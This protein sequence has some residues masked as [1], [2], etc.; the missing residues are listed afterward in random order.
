MDERIF[1]RLDA[2][3][4]T[5]PVVLASVLVTRGAV[6]RK[7]GSRMLVWEDGSEFSV[8]GGLAEARVIDAARSLLHDVRG[9]THATL[10]IDL[11]GR[12][13]SAGICGGRMR[14]ALRRWSGTEDVA[15]IATTAQRLRAGRR[16]PFTA[17]DL[18]VHASDAHADDANA[19]HTQV[20]HPDD[21]LLIV[22]GGHCS[23]ALFQLAQWLDFDRWVFDPRPHYF[24]GGDFDGATL[25]HGDVAQLNR[26][27]GSD[28]AVHVA[29]LNRDF[30]GD[31][32]A[33]HVLQHHV[34][35]FL[36]MMG[37]RRR[38]AEVRAAFP[39][40]APFQQRLQAPIGED[41]GAHTPHEIAVSILA[42]L[43]RQRHAD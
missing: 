21:R 28:R 22:G 23:L 37:S 30:A 34:P 31:V 17:H 2:L 12:P 10:D 35:A 4:A 18:G 38:I 27:F 19:A 14:V 5:R 6:P 20:L 8:G 41:I 40:D 25:L 15:R 7:A 33:L 29:L 13:E 16:M 3:L 9:N 42:T 39:A 32:A 26:A 43:V 36:G 1:A 11:G 24:T